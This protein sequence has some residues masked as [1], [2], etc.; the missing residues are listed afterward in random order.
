MLR[1][2]A[3][4]VVVVIV[5]IIAFTGGTTLLSSYVF[6]EDAPI[7][8]INFSHKIHATDNEIPCQQCHIYARRSRSS[9]VPP[10]QRCMGCHATVRTDSPEIKKLHAYWNEQKPIPWVKIHNVPDYV[11]FPHKRHIRR[12]I[13]CQECHGPVETMARV[14]REAPLTMGWCL[15]CHMK[16]NPPGPSD[17]WACHI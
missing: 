12:G 11:Y 13:K 1:S 17:C 16:K 3:T 2:I 15:G 10:V 4:A 8:P 7:Q 9:G 6:K 14:R 5:S